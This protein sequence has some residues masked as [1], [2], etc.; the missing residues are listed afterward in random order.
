[1]LTRMQ[2]NEAD[3]AL[4]STLANKHAVIKKTPFVHSTE[5]ALKN[6]QEIFDN[7]ANGIVDVVPSCNVNASFSQVDISL[8]LVLAIELYKRVE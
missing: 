4:M 8:S 2:F 5:A 7:F 6:L 1:M 3:Q